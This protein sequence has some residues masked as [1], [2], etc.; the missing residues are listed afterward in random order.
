MV[1]RQDKIASEL[2]EGDCLQIMPTLKTESFDLVI[3]DPPY[4]KVVGEKRDYLA[5]N[6][7][8]F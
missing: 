3:A 8:V 2:I 6:G 4:W 1:T 7:L 5:H